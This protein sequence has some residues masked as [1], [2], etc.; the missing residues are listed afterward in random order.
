MSKKGSK[1]AKKGKSESCGGLVF[2][3][4]GSKSERKWR[5]RACGP[6]G[7]EILAKRGELPEYG[8]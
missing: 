2:E 6:E 8:R 1:M 7:C 3:S 4:L 5:I